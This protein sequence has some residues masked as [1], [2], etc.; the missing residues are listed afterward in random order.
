[1]SRL[2]KILVVS[3]SLVVLSYVGLGFVMAKASGDRAYRSLTVF[4]EVLHHIQ[5]DWVE[6]PDMRL[7]TAGALHGLL[8][9]LDPQS[10]YLSPREYAEYKKFQEKPPRGETGLALSK[11]FGYVAVLSVLPESPAAKAG[12]QSGDFLERIAGFTTREMSVGQA[13]VLLRGEPGTGVKVSVVRGGRAEPQELDLVRGARGNARVTSDK[14]PGN[15][16]GRMDIGYL[17]V[18]AL[19]AGKADEIS[20]KLAQMEREGAQK[21][22]LDLRDCALGEVS[23]GVN[24]ARLFVGSGTIA[25]LQGQT[26]ARQEFV[27]EPT[28]VR[29]NHPVV[30]LTSDTT[31]GAAEIVAAAIGDGKRGEVVGE[32]T[33]GTASQQ[34]LIPLEDGAALVLTVGFYYT[35]AGKPIPEE[36]VVPTVAVNVRD[37]FSG[38]TEG[39]D[40]VLNKAL[41][42]LKGVTVP[43]KAAQKLPR[44][45]ARLAGAA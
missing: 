45:A 24:V 3:L 34:K 31:S 36:G 26:V 17:R 16:P 11:R 35:P 43:A 27:A 12:I 14:F 39:P 18:P 15:E 9:V 32:R 13:Q 25:V 7:V 33:F 41:E 37:D 21:L 44:N 28:K 1:M 5:Q 22:I 20:Q 8:E 2:S 6:E 19:D 30:V 42:I 29:W 23:E 40:T 38:T 4:G 10:G